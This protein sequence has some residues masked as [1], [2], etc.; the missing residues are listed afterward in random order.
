MSST[1]P[2]TFTQQFASEYA[3]NAVPAMLK[4]I[5]SIKRYNRFVLLGALLTSY[6]HQAHYLWT[7]NAGYFAYLVPLIFDAAMVSM[8]TVVRT[9]GIARDAKRGALIVFACAAMLSATINFA[10]PGS[11]GLRLVFALVVV[12][13]IGV[14]LVA[15]RIRPDFA[16]IEAEAA[17]LLT[18]ARNL[19]ATPEHPTQPE[20]P[21]EPPAV[22]PDTTEPAA[23]TTAVVDTPPAAAP[24]VIEAPVLTPIPAARPE[25]PAHLVPTAR[26]AI[27]QHEQTN[28]RP[29]TA[30]ELAALL[31]VT[32]AI[33]RE[34][35]HSING[36]ST[37]VN[38]TPVAGGAR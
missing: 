3:R 11:L 20:Q 23:D 24:A 15:G 4:A 1:D 33:A 18:A 13:V 31:T 34:L 21:T 38:G 25:V 6:L 17:A 10:S 9:S 27:R 30:D 32:P 35:L 8:L 28:G 19:T 5:G 12:L 22:T 14:E 29:I 36:H 26:F 2:S 37:A 7:Q 16:A